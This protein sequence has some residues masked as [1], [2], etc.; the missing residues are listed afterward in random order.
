MHGSRH[1]AFDRVCCS[2]LAVMAALVV[3]AG[4]AGAQED[5]VQRDLR[6]TSGEERRIG[7]YTYVQPDCGP[8]PLPEVKLVSPPAHGAVRVQRGR[9][10]LTNFKQCLSVNVPALA[11]F[12]RAANNF[13]GADEFTLEIMTA[14][15]HKQVQHFRMSVSATPGTEEKL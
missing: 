8:G 14:D 7:V 2:C 12:Y 4:S 11:A 10:K 1:R 13:T 15:R 6:A 9:V 5:V 3:L